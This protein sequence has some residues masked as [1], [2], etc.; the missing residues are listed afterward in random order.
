[1]LFQ[2]ILTLWVIN[3]HFDQSFIYDLLEM[4]LIREIHLIFL[5]VVGGESNEWGISTDLF[6]GWLL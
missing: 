3:L 4:G 1:M 6:A 2:G 5:Q